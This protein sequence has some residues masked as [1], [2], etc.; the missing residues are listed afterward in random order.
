MTGEEIRAALTVFAAR[1][2]LY[3]GSERGE[4]QT[5]CNE[6]FACYGTNRLDAGAVFE[7]PQH[8]R[9]LDL[10]WR[11]Q[12]I[13]EM[14]RPSEAAHL[15][16]HRAQALA[17]WRDSAD[18]ALGQPAPRYVV[19]C[20]FQKLEVWEPGQFPT[21]PR[22]QLDLIDL[23][24]Q[25][26]ALLFLAESEPVFAGGHI[27]V[28]REA[29]AHLTG[30]Y[31]ELKDRD[32]AHPDVLRDFLLQCVWCLFAEDLAQIP[33]H[34][35]MRVV[36]DLIA[37]ESRSSADDLHQLFVALNTPGSPR[38]AHGIGKDVP[39]ANGGLFENPARVHLNPDELRGL[40][41]AA[42]FSWR[43]VEPAIFGSLLEGALG[44]DRQWALGA[45]Y[46]HEADILKVVQPTIVEP[47]RDRIDNITTLAEARSAQDDLTRYVVL[48]P[49]CGSG[50]F[51][52]VA[53][54]EL[55]RLEQQLRTRE[56]ELRDASGASSSRGDQQAIGGLFLPDL[57][58]QG[59]RDRDVRRAACPS[60]V[61]DGPQARRRTVPAG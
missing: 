37:H 53:Y 26:D 24:D 20:A 61:V 31:Q 32:A 49:A 45:H 35:F 16:A 25:Y 59:D 19:L 2:S 11:P 9:F 21:Q 52:Y 58:P 6:L 41:S 44:R 28:T 29:V 56:Q 12:C 1:W 8:G 55:R 46:T 7:D 57:Q 33:E 17:Y 40:W 18:A 14:K 27:S 15:S 50:N 48:D 51:L 3:G 30:L 42:E 22:V 47:W 54:R 36:E 13:I 43:K 23:P 4:A 10:I 38:Q 5:F 60:D 34:R 39:Y